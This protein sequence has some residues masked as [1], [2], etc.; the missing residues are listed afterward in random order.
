[1]SESFSCTGEHSPKKITGS[2]KSSKE[3]VRQ[4]ILDLCQIQAL[5]LSEISQLLN[6]KEDSLRNHYI[7]PMCDQGLLKRLYPN[8]LTHPKQKYYTQKND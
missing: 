1:M 4:L 6:R 3:L 8:I 2:K 5:S 7:N